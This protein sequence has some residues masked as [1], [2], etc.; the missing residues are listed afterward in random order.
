MY[1]IPLTS[2]NRETDDRLGIIILIGAVIFSALLTLLGF[3]NAPYDS[4]CFDT[5]GKTSYEICP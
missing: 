2:K 5:T 3:P 4:N 1:D